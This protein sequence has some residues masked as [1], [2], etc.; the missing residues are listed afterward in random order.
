MIDAVLLSTLSN[1]TIY[2]IND[3]PD[4][5]VHF[6]EIEPGGKILKEHIKIGQMM[7]VCW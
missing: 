6:L 1:C 4:Y 3:I 7:M 2:D 5:L